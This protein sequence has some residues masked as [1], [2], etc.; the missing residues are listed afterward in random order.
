MLK[1]RTSVSTLLLVL[2]LVVGQVE[3][4]PEVASVVLCQGQPRPLGV[5]KDH[6][7]QVVR[8]VVVL[9]LLQQLLNWVSDQQ[10]EEL[11]QLLLEDGHEAGLVDRLLLDRR[12]GEVPD[13]HC[14]AG[15]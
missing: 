7:Q 6:G 12:Q 13:S 11:V 14:V 1:I 3:A 9:V 15:I 4:E 2:L 8:V 5:N 10:S